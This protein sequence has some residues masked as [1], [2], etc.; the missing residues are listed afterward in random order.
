MAKK[1][2]KAK[3][4]QGAGGGQNF[5]PKRVAGMRVPRVLRQG[6]VGELL[7]SPLGQAIV[8][9]AVVRAGFDT[10]EHEAR[11]GSHTRQALSHPMEGLRHVGEDSGAM[12]GNVAYAIN[13]AARAFVDAMQSGPPEHRADE[14]ARERPG[15]KPEGRGPEPFIA[16]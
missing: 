13:Q 15:K 14:F 6:R 2:K 16:H 12:S 3:K 9:E 5:L 1:A 4:A 8:A 7:A 10:V 11:P